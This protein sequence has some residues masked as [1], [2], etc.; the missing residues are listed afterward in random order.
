[1]CS[2]FAPVKIMSERPPPP[3]LK[4]GSASDEYFKRYF[5]LL[6]LYVRETSRQIQRFISNNDLCTGVL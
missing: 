4:P 5:L 6:N 2:S 3:L 1:M